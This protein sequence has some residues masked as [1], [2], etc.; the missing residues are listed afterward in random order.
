MIDFGKWLASTLKD[1]SITQTELSLRI[2]SDP[3]DVNEWAHGKRMPR[4]DT[5]QKIVHGLGYRIE[6]VKSK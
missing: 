6:I 4:F 2:D 5:A 3:G 1:E